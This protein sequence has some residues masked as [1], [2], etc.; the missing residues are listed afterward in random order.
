MRNILDTKW[1]SS[2]WYRYLFDFGA[3]AGAWP[4]ALSLNDKFRIILCRIKGHPN[5]PVFY[6]LYTLEPDMSC[7]DCGDEI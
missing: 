7:K 4:M 3:V 2:E 6:N 1:L 5:G